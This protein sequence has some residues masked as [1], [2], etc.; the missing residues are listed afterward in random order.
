MTPTPGRIFSM[1]KK[2][3]QTFGILEVGQVLPEV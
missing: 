3:I 2:I 1:I